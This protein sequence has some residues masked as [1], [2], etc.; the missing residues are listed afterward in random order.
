MTISKTYVLFCFLI[1]EA[2]P[3]LATVAE[4]FVDEHTKR[5]HI[6]NG[7]ELAED[8]SLAIKCM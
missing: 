7:R 4:D 5:I 3:R 1:V 2:R 8:G 6:T